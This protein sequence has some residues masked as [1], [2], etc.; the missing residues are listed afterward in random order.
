MPGNGG[1][2]GE[3]GALSQADA[4]P[5][6]TGR[7]VLDADPAALAEIAGRLREARLDDVLSPAVL[8]TVAAIVSR[9]HR[10]R[11]P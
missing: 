2:R 4:G 8:A 7:T 5:A 10:E 9:L 3:E 11:A 6:E 1:R